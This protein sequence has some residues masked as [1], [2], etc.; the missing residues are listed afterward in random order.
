MISPNISNLN[1]NSK[2]KKIK[3]KNLDNLIHFSNLTSKKID[4]IKSNDGNDKH[5]K[6]N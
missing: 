5:S 6:K 3:K 1:T 2:K 4:N